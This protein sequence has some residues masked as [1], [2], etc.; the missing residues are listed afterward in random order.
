MLDGTFH[1]SSPILVN[2]NLTLNGE[3]NDTVILLVEGS[4]CNVIE[5]LS[6]TGRANVCI[7]NLR[8]NG[9]GE[10]QSE[11]MR[12]GD[13]HAIFR[14][15]NNAVYRNLY[16]EN[17]FTGGIRHNGGNNIKLLYSVIS[18]CPWRGVCLVDSF[19]G[20]ICRNTFSNCGTDPEQF[21]SLSIIYGSGHVVEHNLIEGGGHTAQ[22]FLW[23]VIDS[24]ANY[25]TAL[26]GIYMGIIIKGD[27][28]ELVG[29][30]VQRSG[31]N[32]LGLNKYLTG[33]GRLE[34]NYVSYVG[35]P[36]P[37]PT[38]EHAGI[39]LGTDLATVKN[40]TIEFC[41]NNGIFISGRTGNQI[42]GNIISNCGQDEEEYVRPAGIAIQIWTDEMP[43]NQGTVIRDNTCYDDQGVPTQKHGLLLLPGDGYI[44]DLVVEDNDFSGVSSTGI[45][46][47][48]EDR[49][50]NPTIRNN[51]GVE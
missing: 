25:N 30:V 46:I 1:I 16:I 20:E 11:G 10:N 33:G 8:I 40:N 48:N 34:D 23:E 3:D 29:N 44:D 17:C 26:D 5:D 47:W 27:N 45:K 49:V 43:I 39:C 19:N 4:N 14:D 32:A 9:N 51:L 36:S 42:I 7:Q 15:G 13:G 22:I 38:T 35:K 28:S 50:R 18:D 37:R 12:W 24:C 6:N 2:D 21:I 31:E 41:G